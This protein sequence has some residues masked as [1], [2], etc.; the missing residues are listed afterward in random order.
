MTLADWMEVVLLERGPLP[1]CELATAVCRRKA[2]VSAELRRDPRFVQWGRRRASRWGVI[3]RPTFDVGWFL[4]RDPSW[5]R[6]DVDEIVAWLLESGFAARVHRN[7]CL[8]LTTRGTEAAAM[9]EA[10]RLDR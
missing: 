4:R 8:A 2:V 1:A 7:G 6:D 3:E 10:L 9:V 5:R